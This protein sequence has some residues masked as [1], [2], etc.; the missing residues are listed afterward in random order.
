MAYEKKES[1]YD[2]SKDKEIAK[3]F[4]KVGDKYWNVG[5]YSYDGGAPKIRIQP[6]SK[7]TNPNATPDKQWITQKGLTGLTKEDAL[8]LAVLLEKIVAMAKL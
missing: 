3:T 5:V 4:A 1:S 7:N 6:R 8:Q 2:K